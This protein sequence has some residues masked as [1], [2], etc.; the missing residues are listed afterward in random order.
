LIGI[1]LDELAGVISHHRVTWIIGSSNAATTTKSLHL[2]IAVLGVNSI[3]R[4]MPVMNVSNVSDI[5]IVVCCR[6][7]SDLQKPTPLTLACNPPG[8]KSTS[9]LISEGFKASLTIQYSNHVENERGVFGRNF[10]GGKSGSSIGL[11]INSK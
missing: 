2:S 1:T 10:G 9:R 6:P 4:T 7:E 3:M 5:L 11:L 8:M